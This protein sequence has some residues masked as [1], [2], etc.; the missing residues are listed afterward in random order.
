MK[1]EDLGI[2]VS[3]DISK[4]GGVYENIPFVEKQSFK[5]LLFV[6]LILILLILVLVVY[7]FLQEWY[8]RK[9]ESHLFKNKDELYN[10]INFVSHL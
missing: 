5:W 8:K 4:L 9:Y 10:L 2:Y 3:P 6:I 1:L 7:I